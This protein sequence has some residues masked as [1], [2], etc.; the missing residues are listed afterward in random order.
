MELQDALMQVSEIRQQIARSETF[1]GFRS[2]PAGLSA[3][4]AVAAAAVQPWLV[5]DPQAEPGRYLALWISAALFSVA[6][7][8]GEMLIRSYRVASPLS[9]R[10]MWLAVEQFLPCTIV[11]GA[12]TFVLAWHGPEGL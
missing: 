9:T 2:V 5:P 3:A 8:A 1:R 12:V 10:L 7:T 6:V 11:G 4:V